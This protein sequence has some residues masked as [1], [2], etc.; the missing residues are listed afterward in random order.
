LSKIAIF[1]S[2]GLE[3]GHPIDRRSFLPSWRIHWRDWI[4]IRLRNTDWYPY[5][6]R[7]FQR[8]R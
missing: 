8:Y 2:L 6:P 7:S 1:L 5:V 4:R 3:K